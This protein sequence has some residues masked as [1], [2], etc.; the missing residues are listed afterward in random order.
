MF[1]VV[2]VVGVGLLS[3]G[4]GTGVIVAAVSVAQRPRARARITYKG[5]IC[6]SSWSVAT[7]VTSSSGGRSAPR[8][9]NTT[10]SIQKKMMGEL[11]EKNDTA[12]MRRKG[13]P[14]NIRMRDDELR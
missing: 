13:G 7:G 3:Y 4:M 6:L 5:P 10:R 2:V 14:D 11:L 12:W 8:C 9:R 1:V